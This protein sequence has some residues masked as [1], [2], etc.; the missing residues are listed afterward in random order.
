MIAERVSSM[1]AVCVAPRRDGDVVMATLGPDPAVN[2]RSAT[3]KHPQ[4]KVRLKTYGAGGTRAAHQCLECGRKVGNFV[5]SLAVFEFWDSELESRVRLDYESACLR[6]RE[7]RNEAF[8]RA[9]DVASE[10]WWAAYSRYLKTPVW[11][12]KRLLVLRRCGD[13]CESCG[14]RRAEHVHHL[15]YPETFGLEPLFDLVGVCVPCHRILHPHMAAD[16][17]GD[18]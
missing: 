5:S 8:S 7:K 3:C 4:T 18:A 15:K 12:A 14:Q 9:R 11:K 1:M 2:H 13:T 16:D 10:A 6:W 17:P